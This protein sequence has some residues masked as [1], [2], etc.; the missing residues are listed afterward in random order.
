MWH[1]TDPVPK[2][3]LPSGVSTQNLSKK[4]ESEKKLLVGLIF[5]IS[6]GDDV[7]V[8]F[9]VVYNGIVS[10]RLDNLVLGVGLTFNG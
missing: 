5:G 9:Y 2:K 8:T 4:Y 6:K 10:F 7:I 1:K 3:Y